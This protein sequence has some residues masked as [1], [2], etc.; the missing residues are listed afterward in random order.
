MLAFRP[1]FCDVFFSR[2][3]VLVL[4]QAATASVASDDRAVAAKF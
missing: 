1:E 3:R 4:C 2:L